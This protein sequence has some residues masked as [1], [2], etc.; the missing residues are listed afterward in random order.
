MYFIALGLTQDRDRSTEFYFFIMLIILDLFYVFHC[1]LQFLFIRY[2][3]MYF[4]VIFIFGVSEFITKPM[5][6]VW[7]TLFREFSPI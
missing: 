2:D 3:E 1:K 4:I 6:N 5:A 7:L